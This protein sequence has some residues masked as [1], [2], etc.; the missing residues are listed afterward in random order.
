MDL[1]K[2]KKEKE[3]ERHSLDPISC[4]PCRIVGRTESWWETSLTQGVAHNKW[5]YELI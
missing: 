4:F 2:G 5:N 3:E 1:F